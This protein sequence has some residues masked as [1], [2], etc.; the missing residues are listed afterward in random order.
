VQWWLRYTH[1]GL[2]INTLT[3]DMTF[4]WADRSGEL[5]VERLV[6]CFGLDARTREGSLKLGNRVFTLH[7]LER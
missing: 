2:G 3:S 7:S 4:R 6:A 1:L 5:L